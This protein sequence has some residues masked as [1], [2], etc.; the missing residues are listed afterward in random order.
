MARMRDAFDALNQM[1]EQREA[2]EELDPSFEEFMEQFGD[3]FPGNP[4]TLDELLEQLAERMAAA[5]AMWN[6]LS[7]EQQ[8]QLR[9]LAD[10]VLEDMDLRWQ[11]DRLAGTCSGPCPTPAGSSPTTSTARTRWA[12]TG[13]PTWPRQLGQLDRMEEVL[14]SASTPAALGE[15]D[16]DQVRQHMG[17]DAARSLDRL[18]KLTKSLADAGLIE[19]QGGRIELTP[20]GHAPARPEGAVRPLRPDQQGPHRRPLGPAHR[21]R[22]T[23]ARRRPRPTSTATRSTCTSRPP[24][25]TRCAGAARACRSASRPRTSRWSRSR[26]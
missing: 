12:W 23:T 20:A 26:R 21:R 18:A 17:E 7:P 25:T 14:Q 2:G 4:Q 8:A 24:C 13:P 1:L 19:Q 9:Q 15:I 3:M 6:S 10:A 5:Q 22:A 11:V 16:L